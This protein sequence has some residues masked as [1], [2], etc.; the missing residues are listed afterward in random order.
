MYYL[1]NVFVGKIR[2]Y[3][4]S[5]FSVID[6]IQVDGELQ[7]GDFGFDGDQQVEKKIYGGLDCVLCYYLCEY[8]VDWICD[9]FQQVEWFCVLVFGEN[10]FIIGFIE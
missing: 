3:V 1:V 5:C 7:F 6:K 2:D 4:G 8:Y 9:F 10:F